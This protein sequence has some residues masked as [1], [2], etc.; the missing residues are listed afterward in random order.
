MPSNRLFSTPGK[1]G[2]NAAELR[3]KSGQAKNSDQE[4]LELF[5]AS[6]VAGGM[7]SQFDPADID[8]SQ[9]TLATNCTIRDSVTARRPGNNLITPTAPDISPVLGFF[10]YKD[11]IGVVTLIR[12]TNN[13]NPIKIKGAAVWTTIVGAALNIDVNA[14]V[15]VVIAGTFLGLAT[16]KDRLQQINLTTNTYAAAGNA[17][18]Y[19]YW[20]SHNNRIIGFN[21]YDA[22]T[23]APIQLGT[24]GQFNPTEWN[25]S[26]DPSAAIFQ[27]EDSLSSFSDF[28]TGI[29]PFGDYL[30]VIRER[31]LWLGSIQ[32]SATIPY[33]FTNAIPTMGCDT[34]KSIQQ[35]PSGV[36]YYDRRL[37]N[38]FEY[39]LGKSLP[40]PIGDVIRTELRQMIT[41][42][43]LVFS[44]Y[45]ASNDEYILGVPIGSSNVVRRWRYNR[46]SKAWSFDDIQNLTALSAL[47]YPSNSITID[48][49]IGTIDNLLGTIDG[50]SP[51]SDIAS[52]F[53][54]YNNGDLAIED[55]NSDT[56]RGLVFN[57]DLRSKLFQLP[58]NANY[59]AQLHI[60]YIPIRAGGFTVYY[61]KD[62][63]QTFITYKSITYDNS[64][65]G[66][67]LSIVCNKNIRNRAYMWK[68]TQNT[69]ICDFV[70]YEAYAFTTAGYTRQKSG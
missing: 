65:L 62:G 16:Q 14:Q 70:E 43:D 28:G 49:L 58:A 46:K 26:V 5:A 4:P 20:C 19:K 44:S 60:T 27:I 45:D 67:R 22:A 29:V 30:L 10:D 39:D 40:I 25:P 12:I 38:V 66:K 7:V 63:G 54:G 8:P 3:I 15:Q 42:P 34:P 52:F 35:T 33:Y 2:V 56:D 47:N 18:K 64:T 69:G 51:A 6:L 57:L 61:S 37:R 32:A 55:V 13:A 31:S 36:C 17:L 50:L 1:F 23:P 59:V 68:V 9:L 21:L 11:P 24:S 53:T 41:N 48:D